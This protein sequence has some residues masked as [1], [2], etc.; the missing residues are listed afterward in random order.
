MQGVFNWFAFNSDGQLSAIGIV[1]TIIVCIAWYM[2]NRAEATPNLDK[3]EEMRH[4]VTGHFASYIAR[5]LAAE[6]MPPERVAVAHDP[7][8]RKIYVQHLKLHNELYSFR[9]E[10]ALDVF[11]TYIDDAVRSH[12]IA[13]QKAG[14]HAD[15]LVASE[16]SA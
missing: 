9:P 14:I 11:E 5:G 4:F 13:A 8:W 12:L 1:L 3:L 10:M 15:P 6:G 7:A 2:S 16:T